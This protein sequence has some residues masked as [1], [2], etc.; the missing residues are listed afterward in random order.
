MS[1]INH[2]ANLGDDVIYSGTVAAATEG[3]FLG[4]PALAVSLVVGEGRHF[5]T[6][7]SVTRQLVTQLADHPL[8]PN[9]ILNVNVPDLPLDQLGRLATTR[10]G[11]RHRSE[12][13]IR[14][15]DPRDRP[16]YWVGNAGSGQDAGPGTDFHAV[17]AGQVS[18]SPIKVDL[19]D[20]GSL[21][22]L[23]DWLQTL[24]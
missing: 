2:G 16:V 1:G 14:T 12:P 9:T 19:T 10:L 4:L 17:A 3:R 7:A 6:A 21:G 13:V 24:V 23:G 18:V 15:M 20:H 8:P 5:D 22:P 11:F